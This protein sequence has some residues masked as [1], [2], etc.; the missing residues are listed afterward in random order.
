MVCASCRRG[1]GH[2]ARLIVSDLLCRPGQQRRCRK[3]LGLVC[4][5]A[6]LWALPGQAELKVAGV[7]DALAANVRAFVQLA[8]EPCNAEPWRIQRRF[9][10]V[11]DQARKALEFYGYYDPEIESALDVAGDCWGATVRIAAGEP[12][13]IRHTDVQVTGAASSDAGFDARLPRVLRPGVRLNHGDYEAFK[14]A[15][16]F[17]ARQRGYVDAR[18]EKN[19]LDVWPEELAADVTLHFDSGARYRMGEITVEQDTFE[20]AFLNRYILMQPGDPYD[21][22][23]LVSLQRSLSDSGYFRRVLVLPNLDAASNE[24]IPI[25]VTLTPLEKIE[26]TIGAGFATDTGPRLRAGYRNRRVNR[27]GHR[28]NASLRASPVQSGIIAEFR[29]PLRDPRAE[30]L[31][32]TGSYDRENTDTSESNAARLGIRR[33]KRL[34]DSWIRTL[35]LDYSY[36]N[37]VVADTRDDSRLVLPGLAFDHKSGD[38]DLYPTTGLRLGAEVRGSHTAIGSS[39]SFLQ[40]IGRVRWIHSFGE[41]TRLISRASIGWTQ[42][43]EFDELPPSVRFFAGGDETVRGFGFESLGPEDDAGEVI[44]G[45]RLAIASLELERQ[46][47]GNFYGA[48]FVDAGNAFNG[49]DVDP[50]VGVGLGVKWRSP[51][52]AIRLYLAHPLNKSDQDVRVHISLGPEL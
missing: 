40:L 16:Q 28:L 12:V 43:D 35:S 4:G 42:D 51:I 9:S 7:D 22:E 10:N 32:Y 49:S 31:S 11:E 48:V 30:W 44:G 19:R 3:T 24:E 50:A 18:F 1:A 20:P 41:K 8:G 25:D 5:I 17:Q 45:K 47:R 21:A 13:R 52:G 23:Q 34:S 29:Q 15:L 39:T 33:S 14:S 37:F 36:E 26:Y 46:V 2:P 38:L 27:R 6:L